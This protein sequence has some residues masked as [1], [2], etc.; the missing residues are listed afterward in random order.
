MPTY[1]GTAG[2]DG[3]NITIANGNS[4]VTFNDTGSISIGSTGTFQTDGISDG[5]KVVVTESYDGTLPE[6]GFVISGCLVGGDYG[7]YGSHA[8]SY[9]PP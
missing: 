1:G 7:C 6:D 4:V 8:S 5:D 2:Q 3:N 9:A